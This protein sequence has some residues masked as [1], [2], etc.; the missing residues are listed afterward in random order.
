LSGAGLAQVSGETATGTQQATFDAMNL[1][2]GLLTDPFIGGRAETPA[3][4]AGRAT[5]SNTAAKRSSRCP[6][7]A[8]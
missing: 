1:F 2:L 7:R 3:P 5:W 6:W 8:A 4:A